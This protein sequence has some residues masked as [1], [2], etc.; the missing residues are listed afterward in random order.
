MRSLP[1]L[2]EKKERMRDQSKMLSNTKLEAAHR[3]KLCT[4]KDFAS[5]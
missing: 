3:K 1:F 2:I 4:P 5:L